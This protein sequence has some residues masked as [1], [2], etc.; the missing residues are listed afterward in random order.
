MK[1]SL[2]PIMIMALLSVNSF[3]GNLNVNNVQ[4]LTDDYKQV[5][6]PSVS[7]DGEKV[8]WVGIKRDWKINQRDRIFI[9]DIETGKAK[10][11]KKSKIL[12]GDTRCHF[13]PGNQLVIDEILWRPF[14]MIRTTW[15][16]LRTKD[17]EPMGFGSRI[18]FV[19]ADEA[20][21]GK[22]KTIAK[23]KNKQLLLNHNR[24]YIKHTQVSSDGKWMSY[25]VSNNYPKDRGVHLINLES[26]K[27]YRLSDA[28]DKH[29]T[30]SS[31]GKMLLFHHQFKKDG[32]EQS[33][34]GYFKLNFE[35]D[36]LV[37][38]ERH[39]LDTELAGFVYHKHPVLDMKTNLLYFHG[40]AET[41]G[42]KSLM[43]RK[44]E[45]NSEV[46]EIDVYT[47]DNEKL[48]KIK[49]PT[50]DYKDGIVVLGKF[51]KQKHWA[52]YRINQKDLAESIEAIK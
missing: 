9:Q 40:E 46:H 34:L 23:E 20:L 48:D 41:D 52:I 16:I 43:V 50:T 2:V 31:D 51:H 18:T 21:K 3:A 27:S 22:R 29:P 12:N 15:Y 8:C 13:A 6:S 37:S 14:A 32:E 35:N 28:Y 11:L 47:Q 25:Y 7:R 10:A 5:D 24:A 39:L 38:H 1:I 19:D 30:W 49:Q 33:Q 45:E 17:V 42:R 36:E 4:L 26:R 44:F